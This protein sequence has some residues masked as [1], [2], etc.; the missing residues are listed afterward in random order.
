MTGKWI[1]FILYDNTGKTNKYAVRTKDDS[2]FK[3][4]EIRWFGR[5]RKYAFFPESQTV[6]ESQ[7]LGDIAEFIDELMRDRKMLKN[8]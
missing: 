7:C 4:G 1:E 5:W 8:G 6:F 3:L 2:R